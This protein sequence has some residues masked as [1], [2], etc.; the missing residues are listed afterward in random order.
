MSEIL[1]CV[2][3]G[4][5]WHDSAAGPCPTREGKIVCMYC[6]RKC[7]HNYRMDGFSGQRCRERDKA[8]V[9]EKAEKEKK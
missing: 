8:R 6:C 9:K 5:T 4:R 2:V 3:C 1:K 7:R